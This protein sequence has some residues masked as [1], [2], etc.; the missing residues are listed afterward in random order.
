MRSNQTMTPLRF[1]IACCVVAAIAASAEYGHTRYL[2]SRV[3]RAVAE[4]TA[5]N[6]RSIE[7]WN[8]WAATA[9][10]GHRFIL[11]PL[12]CDRTLLATPVTGAFGDLS[13]LPAEQLRLVVAYGDRDA[14]AGYGYMLAVAAFLIGCIP[15]S[16][17]F[18]L[19][20][21]A[22]VADAVRGSSRDGR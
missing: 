12:A 14:A 5:E 2:D 7:K 6:A 1:F 8:E 22:E 15:V 19:R 9:K 13:K 17:Y 18:L 11:E 21:V 3:S 20:R 16:W 4:C 10:E